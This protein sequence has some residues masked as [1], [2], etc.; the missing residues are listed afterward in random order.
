[1]KYNVPR[2]MYFSFNFAW[3]FIQLGLFVKNRGVGVGRW[4]GWGGVGWGYVMDK[5]C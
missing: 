3:D 5:T 1:M 2:D 4:V